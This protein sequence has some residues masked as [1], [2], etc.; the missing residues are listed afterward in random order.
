M[1]MKLDLRLPLI[2]IVLTLLVPGLL[3]AQTVGLLYKDDGAS[4]GLTLFNPQDNT[5]VYL[6]NNDGLVVNS[7]DTGF[8]G[9]SMVYLLPDGSIMRAVERGG[10]A[11]GL[12]LKIQQHDWEGNLIWEFTMDNS[13]YRQ[14]HDIAMLPNG[15][16]L[17]MARQPKSIA[18]AIAAGRD[19]AL[20]SASDVKPESIVE[21]EP[22]LPDGGN[23]VWNWDA[24]DHL[25][26]DFDNMK[27]NF[28]VVADHPE[29]IDL[30][31]GP[32]DGDWHHGNG[33]DYDVDRDQITISIREFNEFWVIDHSTTTAEAAGHA[34]GNSG[35]GGDLLYRWGNPEAYGRG[36]VANKTLFGQHDS[37][38]IPIGLPGA[39]NFTMFNNGWQLP[40]PEFSR[41]DE[42][43][44]PEDEFGNY[45][46]AAGQPY[47]PTAPS[48]SYM[49]S[50]PTS[51]YS[52][53]ISGAD[54][55][56]D[57]TTVICEGIKGRFVEV[58]SG[59]GI[60]WEYI[61][62]ALTTGIANQGDNT[63][64]LNKVFKTRRYPFDYSA[65]D[66]RDL[67]AGDP[68]EGFESPFP[69]PAN[70]LTASR[71]SDSGDVLN[72]EWDASSCTSFDYN[73]LYGSLADV[74][75]LSPT[76]AECDLGVTGVHGW[77]D[78]PDESLYFLIVG[79]DST[80]FY[81][82]NWGESSDGSPRGGSGA[83]FQCGTTTRIVN[84]S[85]E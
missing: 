46:I 48:W 49:G 85:C 36:T 37:R 16:V 26:Q 74:A 73:L 31:Y 61:N 51:F 8:E 13:V 17:I 14:H 67:T 66:G 84:A 5:V 54:R 7:W 34:G 20:I 3:G 57:N 27:P 35:K 28:G 18:E 10:A 38:R 15:N 80:G 45:V 25:V 56:I 21:I 23:I 42:I 32:T 50:P 40:P 44:P 11:E 79:T 62:P 6:I 29:L 78:V 22:I 33:L 19:P 69:V 63:G 9:R 55:T 83:S 76:A 4:E 53:I 70:T 77:S 2:L 75:L 1:L 81:E 71:Q 58:T 60:V 30:N 47:G 41:V 68:I 72:I 59:G 43:T 65:F 24:W 52:P 39:G 64:D 12:G 82:S